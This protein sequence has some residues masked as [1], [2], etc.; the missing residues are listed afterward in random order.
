MTKYEWQGR[1]HEVIGYSDSYWVGCRVI[2]KSTDGEAV[3]IGEHSLMG[4]CRTQN[5]VTQSSVEAELI[6]LVKCS[7]E[8]MGMGSAMSDWGVKRRGVVYASTSAALAIA[9]RDG[10]GKL[11]HINTT[12]QWDQEKQDLHRLEM[13]KVLGTEK[14]QLT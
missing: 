10:A 6:A 14:S 3:L 12:T 11:R 7:A 13:R 5:H 9:N 4:W 2:G 8:P 1:E